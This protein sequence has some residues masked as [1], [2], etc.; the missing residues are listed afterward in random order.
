MPEGGTHAEVGPK[1]KKKRKSAA[2]GFVR[3]RKRNANLCAAVSPI[4]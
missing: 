1:K 3:L 4:D 2:P